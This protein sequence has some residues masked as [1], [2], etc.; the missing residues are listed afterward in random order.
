MASFL[1]TLAKQLEITC[2]VSVIYLFRK[3][4]RHSSV[5]TPIIMSTN[6]PTSEAK[7]LEN[8][9]IALENAINQPEIATVLTDFGYDSDKI[10]EGKAL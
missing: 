7:V 10:N 9:R 6:Q 3:N 2:R 5:N 4:V 1:A 8:Y